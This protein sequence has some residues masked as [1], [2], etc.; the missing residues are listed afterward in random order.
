MTN[1]E[2]K[3][4]VNRSSLGTKS[5][6]AARRSVPNATSRRIV[7]RAQGQRTTKAPAARKG[8]G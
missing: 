5:A 2:I 6:K 4:K 7:A 8:G 1:R 3:A